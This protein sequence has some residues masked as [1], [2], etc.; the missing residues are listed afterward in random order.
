MDKREY[1]RRR[2]RLMDMMG[3]ETVAIIPTAPVNIRNRDVEFPFRPD[4]DFY[5]LTGYSEPEAVAVLIPDRHHGEFVLFCRERDP[6]METWNGR[7]AGLEGACEIFGANDAFPIEDLD[8][9]LP[10]LLEDRERIFYTMGHDA[11]FD[12]RVLGWVNQV[13]KR[14][15]TGVNAPDEFISLNHLLHEMR[16]FKSKS[17]I[18]VMRKAAKISAIAHK[19][20]MAVC[21]PG[22]MEYQIEAELLH[23]FMTHGARSAAY[24][25][26]VGSGENSCILHY[27]ENASELKDGDVLLIDAG[28]E[29]DNYASDIS[30]TFPVN[31]KF[32]KEQRQI[33]E[34][35]LEANLAAIAEVKPGNHWNDP[36]DTAVRILTEGLLSLGILKGKLNALLKEKAYTKYYMHRTGHWLG[37]DVHDVGDYKLDG[38]W[39]KLEPGM[40]TTIEP[41]LYFQPHSGLAK[42][43]WNIGVRIED[44]VLVTDKGNEVFTRDVPK[45]V[46]EIEALMAMGKAA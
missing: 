14:A 3:D 6:K 41:G 35:V 22:M 9:I 39:R 24:P 23:E 43:W 46:D 12:Q 40:V 21:R 28:A 37:M 33:Y 7:R 31:G 29:Y 17:E 42:K 18:A 30:R 16:L 27:T 2:K 11:V 5:Y 1:S 10:G 20:A 13:R 36:H 4:S 25:S 8:D 45:T 32:S 15:R 44:D 38:E 34:L 19:R 26:I